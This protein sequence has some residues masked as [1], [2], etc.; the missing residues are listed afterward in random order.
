[1]RRWWLLL[2][3]GLRRCRLLL[4]LSNLLHWWCRREL[5]R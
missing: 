4:L 2:R 3:V 1:M 5:L